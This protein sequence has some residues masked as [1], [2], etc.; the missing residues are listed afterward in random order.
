MK[1]LSTNQCLLYAM[2]V[3]ALVVGIVYMV[4]SACS[5]SSESSESYA[6]SADEDIN[7]VPVQDFLSRRQCY[8]PG[9][10]YGQYSYAGCRCSRVGT[11]MNNGEVDG[12]AGLYEPPL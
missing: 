4:S 7:F 3:A 12:D 11:Q 1:R 5:A 6:T 9:P 8:F 2:V 10:D